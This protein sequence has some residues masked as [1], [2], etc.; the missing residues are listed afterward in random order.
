MRLLHVEANNYVFCLVSTSVNF[1]PGAVQHPD[2]PAACIFDSLLDHT[3]QILTVSLRGGVV[4]VKLHLV[5]TEVLLLIV[6]C[7][8]VVV[9]AEGVTPNTTIDIPQFENYQKHQNYPKQFL[10][11]LFR[12]D[13]Y[14][15]NVTSKFADTGIQCNLCK[16]KDEDR[17]HFFFFQ[18]HEE[19][20]QTLFLCFTNLKIIKKKLQI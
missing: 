7:S 19:I 17:T 12:N 10:I 15:K 14:F 16:I 4:L 18:I 9:C 20:I 1:S 6:F 2:V 5:P 13:L 8:S 3:D 11:K